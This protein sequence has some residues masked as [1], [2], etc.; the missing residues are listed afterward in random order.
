M[1]ECR[2]LLQPAGRLKGQVCSL[3]YELAGPL[4]ADRLSLTWPK[5]TLKYDFA[6]DD[7]LQRPAIIIVVIT[8]VMDLV[9]H[10]II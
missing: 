4:D 9:M 3:A 10:D 5:W 7:S 8:T 1:G 6:F 2:D